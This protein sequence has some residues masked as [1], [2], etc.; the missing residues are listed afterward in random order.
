MGSRPKP[1]RAW[2][3]GRR[4]IVRRR[5]TG[6]NAEVFGRL[7]ARRM[8]FTALRFITIGRDAAGSEHSRVSFDRRRARVPYTVGSLQSTIH[9][10]N[11]QVSTRLSGLPATERSQVSWLRHFVLFNERLNNLT[12]KRRAAT[13]AASQ[14][15][16]TT[17]LSLQRPPRPFP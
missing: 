11:A 9:A 3:Y 6:P 7:C 17:R 5:T 12:Y 10:N 8:G 1:G 15:I 14:L 16:T 2:W 4:D 13:S